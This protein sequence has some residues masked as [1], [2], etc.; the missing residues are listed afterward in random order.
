MDLQPNSHQDLAASPLR[1][2]AK[3]PFRPLLVV[4]ISIATFS[5]SVGPNYHRPSAP[6]PGVYKEYNAWKVAAPNDTINRGAWWSIYRDPTLDALESQVN[7]SNQNIKQA[8]AAFRGALHS[9][10]QLKRVST[11]TAGCSYRARIDARPPW[12][13]CHYR[14]QCGRSGSRSNGRLIILKITGHEATPPVLSPAVE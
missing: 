12:H 7:I 11:L 13:R 4:A 8:E 14:N 2:L 9:V 10:R 6:V 3:S 1:R 5:C